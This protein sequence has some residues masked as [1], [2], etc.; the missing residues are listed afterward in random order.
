MKRLI[1]RIAEES[2]QEIKNIEEMQAYFESNEKKTKF[3]SFVQYVLNGGKKSSVKWDAIAKK[4]IGL[5]YTPKNDRGDAKPTGTYIRSLLNGNDTAKR[6]EV[7]RYCMELIKSETNNDEHLLGLFYNFNDGTAVQTKINPQTAT[8]AEIDQNFAQLVLDVAYKF[9]GVNE[10]QFVSEFAYLQDDETTPYTEQLQKIISVAHGTGR[11][12]GTDEYFI[13]RFFGLSRKMH[14][15]LNINDD[16]IDNMITSKESIVDSFTH[17]EE[18]TQPQP[19]E[20]KHAVKLIELAQLSKEE[21]DAALG[22][23]IYAHERTPE[24]KIKWTDTLRALKDKCGITSQQFADWVKTGA[25]EE[26]LRA[27]IQQ[28]VN[29]NGGQPTQDGTIQANKI[30]LRLNKLA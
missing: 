8:K 17:E 19:T 30:R 4:I 9:A 28:L 2:Q 14:S 15:T 22:V 24:G 16:N 23:D 6:G 26:E 29:P 7:Y 1:R 25:N 3:I 12:D 11:L 10:D 18:N 5:G 21:L 27:K 13:N 20:H